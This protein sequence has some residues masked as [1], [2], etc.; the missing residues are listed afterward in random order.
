LA[1]FDIFIFVVFLIGYAIIAYKHHQKLTSYVL[2]VGFVIQS[3]IATWLFTYS[4]YWFMFN[5][6]ILYVASYL[7]L[8]HKLTLKPF[9]FYIIIYT[10]F[11]FKMFVTFV[12]QD[13][14][15]FQNVIFEPVFFILLGISWVATA[16]YIFYQQDYARLIDISLFIPF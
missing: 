9:F 15:F 12:L 3:L 10:I 16:S 1:H 4:Y 6:F 14:Y 5:I 13:D 8:K 2:A 11:I 7:M